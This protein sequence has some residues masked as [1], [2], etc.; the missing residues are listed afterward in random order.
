MPIL[1]TNHYGQEDRME[2]IFRLG[3][4]SQPW[5]YEVSLPKT[6]WILKWKLE[7]IENNWFLKMYPDLVT[8][9]YKHSEQN[10]SFLA[11]IQGKD[12]IGTCLA[13]LAKR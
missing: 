5:N 7:D 3:L 2:H 6:K 11:R 9:V 10:C 1:W 12:L 13:A 8:T 4:G